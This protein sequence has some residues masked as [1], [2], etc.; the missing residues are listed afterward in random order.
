MHG[1]RCRKDS[2]IRCFSTQQCRS[3]GPCD[4]VRG[5][6]SRDTGKSCEYDAECGV[7]GPCVT[8]HHRRCQQDARKHCSSDHDCDPCLA[9][10]QACV[11]NPLCNPLK[12]KD[13]KQRVGPC[14]TF[15]GRGLCT[16]D[17][18]R[19]CGT[20]EHC[21][22]DCPCSL[23]GGGAGVPQRVRWEGR[24]ARHLPRQGSAQP[25]W[26]PKTPREDRPGV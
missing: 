6:C 1:G 8:T 21:G 15:G 11:A 20:D 25:P 2:R 26:G 10:R 16:R 5:L 3:K 23:R 14:A 7:D 18:A 24:D 12:Y 4:T 13:C 19:A 17:S 22:M 9:K